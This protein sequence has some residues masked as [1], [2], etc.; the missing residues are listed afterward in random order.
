MYNRD[1]F[2]WTPEDLLSQVN[3]GAPFI[4]YLGHSNE[5]YTLD[6]SVYNITD[7]YFYGLDGTTHNFSLLYNEGCKA[8]A[9]DH[10]DCITE[11][12]L[13]IN[14]FAVGVFANTRYGWF[15]EGQTEGLV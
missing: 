7:D 3:K 11:E 14:N 1:N 15:N 9:F 10:D 4:H 13:K 12:M 8:A 6:L 2:F 5:I